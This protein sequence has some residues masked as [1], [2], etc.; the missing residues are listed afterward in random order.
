MPWWGWLLL[1][2]GGLGTHAAVLY[3]GVLIGTFL[4]DEHPR[5]RARC[6]VL[7]PDD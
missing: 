3:Y 4:A 5:C 6:A 1:G 7:I 2:V